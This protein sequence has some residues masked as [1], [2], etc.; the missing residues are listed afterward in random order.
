MNHMMLFYTVMIAILPWIYERYVGTIEYVKPKSDQVFNWG[1]VAKNVYPILLIAYLGFYCLTW[2]LRTTVNHTMISSLMLLML[3]GFAYWLWWFYRTQDFLLLVK[4]V[5]VGCVISILGSS[6]LPSMNSHTYMAIHKSLALSSG[7]VFIMMGVVIV[8][9]LF[10]RY[11]LKTAKIQSPKLSFFS[12]ETLN[13][14]QNKLTVLGLVLL[15]ILLV[16][17]FYFFGSHAI[18]SNPLLFKKILPTI[19]V[20]F[21][22]ILWLLIQYFKGWQSDYST[23]VLT[24][25]VLGVLL[26]YALSTWFGK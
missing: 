1:C 16:T 6:E 14:W 15:S 23:F 11:Q 20:W 7:I 22:C 9:L 19:L 17:S 26:L 5:S 10:R 2:W 24:M 3:I 12:L 25:I 21:A 4:V 18:L 8:S 13:Q